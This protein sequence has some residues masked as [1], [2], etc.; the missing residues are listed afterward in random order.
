M[1]GILMDFEGE[2]HCLR[3]HQAIENGAELPPLC[4]DVPDP[5]AL[6]IVAMLLAVLFGRFR[7]TRTG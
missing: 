4:S 5:S 7:C 6:L 1:P 2:P 3:L